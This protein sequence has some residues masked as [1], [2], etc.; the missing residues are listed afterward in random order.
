MPAIFKSGIWTGPAT[1]GSSTQTFSIPTHDPLLLTYL[2]VDTQDSRFAKVTPM[3]RCLNNTT[4]RLAQLWCEGRMA[5]LRYPVYIP[6]GIDMI[7]RK[8]F[9]INVITNSAS[10]P[11]RYQ[12]VMRPLIP[13]TGIPDGR[14]K[15]WW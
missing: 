14:K 1:P 5:R 13:E 15:G 10:D 6:E 12:Y 7:G 8:E 11:I 3:V 9:A 4:Y 2:Q